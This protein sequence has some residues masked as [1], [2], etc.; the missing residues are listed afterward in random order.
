M[1]TSHSLASL[2]TSSS[3]RTRMLH[4]AVHLRLPFYT[5]RALL[6][7]QFELRG[8]LRLVSRSLLTFTGSWRQLTA[9][10]SHPQPTLP[11]SVAPHCTRQ[12]PRSQEDKAQK[13][14]IYAKLA[15]KVS[16]GRRSDAGI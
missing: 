1:T 9:T 11:T 6:N 4:H 2:L 15:L 13:L 10:Y 3:H 14:Q 7:R 5:D 8:Y 12:L 16:N